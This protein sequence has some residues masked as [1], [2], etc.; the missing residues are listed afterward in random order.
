[1]LQPLLLCS[2]HM[3]VL[4]AALLCCPLFVCSQHCSCLILAFLF[5][6]CLAIRTP[7]TMGLIYHADLQSNTF[8]P[9]G[10]IL[11]VPVVRNRV[12]IT[13]REKF[14][15]SLFKS[16]KVSSHYDANNKVCCFFF[17][18]QKTSFSYG[19]I[20]SYCLLLA[21]FDSINFSTTKRGKSHITDED[22][23]I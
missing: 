2:L 17:S 15:M 9:L 18:F 20:S 16:S 11:K 6:Y 10:S 12:N 21:F 7:P 1:M 22:E 4:L 19:N 13:A 14:A 5:D 8:P 23:V 3:V